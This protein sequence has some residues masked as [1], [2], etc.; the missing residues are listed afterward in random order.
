MTVQLVELKNGT[1]MEMHRHVE[2]QLGF[3]IKGKIEFTFGPNQ[4]S[5]IA[6]AGMFFF[7][8][9]DESHGIRDTSENTLIVDV[10]GPA[11]KSYL[12]LA[13]LMTG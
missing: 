3:V 4:Q 5:K 1:T 13:I 10:F 12:P 2:E 9:S 6:E 8:G 11:R 7:F